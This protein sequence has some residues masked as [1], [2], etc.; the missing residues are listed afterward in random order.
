MLKGSGLS[1]SAA[2]EVLIG[3][4]LN[5]LYNEGEVSAVEIAQ[6][7]Q[8]AENVYFGKPSGLMDQMACSVGSLVHI[9]FANVKRPEIE[10]VQL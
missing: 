1:S 8:F 3:T 5:G 4:I 2:Y 7:A 9:N 10:Q 6:I